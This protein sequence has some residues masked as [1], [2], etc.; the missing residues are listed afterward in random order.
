MGGEVPRAMSHIH[1]PFLCPTPRRLPGGALLTTMLVAALLF[2]EARMAQA[3]GVPMRIPLSYLTGVSNYGPQDAGGNAELSFSEGILKLD[4]TGLPA[5]TNET[6]QVWMVKSGTNK[7]VAVGTFNTGAD[8]TGGFTG[9]LTG[10]D[11]YDYDLISLTVEPVPDSD[12]APSA[13][14][15]IGGFFTPIKKQDVPVA[16][17]VISD[18]Q[19][20]TLPN[21]GDRVPQQ[22]HGRRHAAAALLFAVGGV[23]AYLT[24]RRRRS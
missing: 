7:A 20:A 2:G 19:P 18:T 22:N 23:S 24:L 6:Y 12:P 8:G 15:T 3:N 10:L 1:L 14:R 9:K 5:L 11:G 16:G 4:V 17:G 13:K 21:T